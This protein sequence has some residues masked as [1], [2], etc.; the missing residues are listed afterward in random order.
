MT[1]EDW[2]CARIVEKDWRHF[3]WLYVFRR[4]FLIEKKLQF[5]PKI[6]HED[7]AFTTEAVLTASQII[8]IEACLYRYRQNPASLTGSTD[9][10]RV[11]A[12]I[13][14]YFVVVE[15]L[16]Q[17]N[18]RLP[19]RHTTKTLLASEIIGQA[20]QVFEVAKMLRASEQYQRVIAECKTRRFAQS[21]FQHVTNVKRLRQVCRMWLAQSGIAGF[22]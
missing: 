1:G 12:R 17:L 5:R 20:L 3:A 9:V 11:M 6:L 10:S 21:L 13:D 19:M 7:I 2:L 4:Q 18:Q 15:Q 8:Y 16:R 22:R 14:S